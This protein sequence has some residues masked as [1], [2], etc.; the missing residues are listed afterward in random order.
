MG[1]LDERICASGMP[2]ARSEEHREQPVM[3]ARSAARVLQTAHILD[4]ASTFTNS[5]GRRDLH[6]RCVVGHY[7]M[8]RI[9]CRRCFLPNSDSG[10]PYDVRGAVFSGA[11]SELT[12]ASSTTLKKAI[13]ATVSS[14]KTRR[15][16]SP[17]GRHR[18]PFSQAL[19]MS[20]QSSRCLF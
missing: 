20:G 12:D 8:H 4:E 18:M 16:G 2:R 11:G 6:G 19:S 1:D 9:I 3:E 17:G 5:A 13:M 15:D 14:S 10:E 7:Y